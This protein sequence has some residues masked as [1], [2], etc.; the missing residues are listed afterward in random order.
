[1]AIPVSDSELSRACLV[2]ASPWKSTSPIT[3][4]PGRSRTRAVTRVKERLTTAS[5]R[6]GF[7][8]TDCVAN[9]R[10][11]QEPRKAGRQEVR[12]EKGET[13]EVTPGGAASWRQK[14]FGL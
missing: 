5:P 3:G 12:G 14:L 1:M 8:V 10:A 4:R 9:G 2:R 13:K 11:F 7:P 6:P